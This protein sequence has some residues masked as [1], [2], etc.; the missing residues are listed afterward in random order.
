MHHLR[1][2][3]SVR[4]RERFDPRLCEAEH[5]APRPSRDQI[6]LAPV[7][8]SLGGDRQEPE[9]VPGNC[10]KVDRVHLPHQ[11]ADQDAARGS[12]CLDGDERSNRALDRSRTLLTFAFVSTSR[13]RERK[14]RPRHICSPLTE[15]RLLPP[16]AT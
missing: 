8:V 5:L 6:D 11:E 3:V 15:P 12:N 7:H 14:K 2:H 9:R 16:A 13:V 1:H 10:L 4:A